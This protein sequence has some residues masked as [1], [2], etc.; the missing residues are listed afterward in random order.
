MAS[1]RAEESLRASRRQAAFVCAL[2]L[3]WI[4][5]AAQT[6]HAAAAWVKG[7]VRLNVRTGPSNE[8]RILG[9][10]HTGDKVEVLENGTGWTRVRSGDREGWVPEGYLQEEPPPAV[11]LADAQAKATQLAARVQTLEAE[12]AKLGE[13]NRSF[14]E[15]DTSQKSELETLTREN[16]ELKA[17]AAWPE[18]IVGAAILAMG[19]L[20]GWV[21]HVIASRRQRPQRIRL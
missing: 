8:Y 14:G 12:S 1:L 15:R 5:L 6:A 18:R 11:L 3:G 13:E 21:I 19:M 7:E 20:I 16:M 17:G 10:L 4:G 2:A 9:E